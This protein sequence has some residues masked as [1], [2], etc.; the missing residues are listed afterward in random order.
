VT[1][2]FS[3]MCVPIP[4]CAFP[5]SLIPAAVPETIA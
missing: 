3:G 4:S 1:F 5:R 2:R